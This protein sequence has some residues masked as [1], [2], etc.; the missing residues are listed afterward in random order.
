MFCSGLIWPSPPAP[1]CEIVTARQHV[2]TIFTG[3]AFTRSTS[4]VGIPLILRVP[5]RDISHV[6]VKKTRTSVY[7]AAVLFR[8]VMIVCRHVVYDSTSRGGFT[9]PRRARALFSRHGRRARIFARCPSSK[10]AVRVPGV[11]W[12]K[13]VRLERYITRFQ[14]CTLLFSPPFPPSRI[15][16]VIS[17]HACD[18]KHS[19]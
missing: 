5:P 7:G 19:C 12:P 15:A 9:S 13:Y 6:I 1:D 4:C 8:T 18:T 14:V 17:Q 2:N 3:V 16:A 10:F 11:P